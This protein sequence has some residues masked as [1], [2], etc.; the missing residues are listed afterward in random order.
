M[1]FRNK[2]MTYNLETL[3]HIELKKIA[4][5]LEIPVRRTKMQMIQDISHSF[6]EYEKYKREKLDKYIRREQLGQ[7]GKEGI[8][9]LV[10]DKQGKKYAMKT[11][12]KEKSSNTLK[13][14]Y[15]LQKM[16]SK[17]GVAPKVYNYDTVSKYIVMEKMDEHLYPQLQ[18]GIFPKKYQKRILEIYEKLDEAKV[19]HGDANLMNYMFKDGELY[20]IDFGFSREITPRLIKK[21]GTEHPNLHLMTIGFILK[22]Q[23]KNVPEKC[24]AY[25]RKS[26]PEKYLKKYN[27]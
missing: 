18:K 27:L 9:Y 2:Y 5:D 11:F 15:I 14:E 17:M 4:E 8:T 24:Y 16:A 21:L 12:R 26:L 3:S 22:L 19:F 13:L 1:Y 23:E 20:I 6:H 7:K 25:L 10:T